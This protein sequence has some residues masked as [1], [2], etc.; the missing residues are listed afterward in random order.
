MKEMQKVFEKHDAMN[1][2]IV[3]PNSWFGREQLIQTKRLIELN[4][5]VNS[6]NNSINTIN[7]NLSN[8]LDSKK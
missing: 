2:V 1:T 4:G 3:H 5:A 8:L 7:K 6:L